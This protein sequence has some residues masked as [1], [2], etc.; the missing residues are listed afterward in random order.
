MLIIVVFIICFKPAFPF[1]E[2]V[3]NYD[4]IA[5]ELCINKDNLALN[6]NGKCYLMSKLAEESK[7]DQ[8]DKKISFESSFSFVF[9]NDI[10]EL[11]TPSFFKIY[12]LNKFIF[13]ND[14]YSYNFYQELIKPPII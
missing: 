2:Y 9:L 3:L 12:R 14:S 7:Q 4:Y 5:N 1:L 6:C 13:N 8:Q 11:F 10:K